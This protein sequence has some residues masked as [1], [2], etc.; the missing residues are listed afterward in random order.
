MI[1]DFLKQK[2][3]PFII[4]LGIPENYLDLLSFVLFTVYLVLKYVLYLPIY[5]DLI[6]A[7][8]FFIMTLIFKKYNSNNQY[9]QSINHSKSFSIFFTLWFLLEIFF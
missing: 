4:F 1:P 7:V 2:N 9:K 5:M 3:Y 6:I 8:M